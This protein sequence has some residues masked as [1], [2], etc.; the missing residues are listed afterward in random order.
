LAGQTQKTS[1]QGPR[2]QKRPKRRGQHPKKRTDGKK[3][4]FLGVLAGKQGFEA[5]KKPLFFALYHVF[6]VFCVCK[7][8]SGG[9]FRIICPAKKNR[10]KKPT[11]GF[12]FLTGCGNLMA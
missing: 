12:L 3:A 7:W 2:A 6:A 4:R 1:T 9:I 5:I 10:A 11:V 8:L